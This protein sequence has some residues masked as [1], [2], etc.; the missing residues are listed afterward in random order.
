MC[1]CC[2]GAAL[3]PRPI[4]SLLL[5]CL[6]AFFCVGG[7]WKSVLCPGGCPGGLKAVFHF[8]DGCRVARAQSA[9]GVHPTFRFRGRASQPSLPRSLHVSRLRLPP[10]KH[11]CKFSLQGP[12]IFT[13]AGST[14]E[15]FSALPTH[16]TLSPASWGRPPCAPPS[17]AAGRTPFPSG[18]PAVMNSPRC[19]R[20]R[21][22]PEI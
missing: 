18:R 20:V 10:T 5:S 12:I 13:S 21:E 6:S 4:C 11:C 3:R 8:G 1:L 14:K 2:S 19:P 9:F 7:S 22:S 17:S 16:I 15:T